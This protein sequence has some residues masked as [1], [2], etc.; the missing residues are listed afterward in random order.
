MHSSTNTR[1]VPLAIGLLLFA[2]LAGCAGGDDAGGAQP[3]GADGTRRAEARSPGK[4]GV[5]SMVTA[6]SAT[7]KPGAPVDLKF[8][9]ASKPELGKPLQVTVAVVPRSA[10]ISQL[11]LLFQSN[12]A[13]DVQSGSETVADAPADGVAVTHVVTVVPKRE[14][15]YYL[16]AV[17]LVE[18][19]GGSVAR[20][21][22]IPIIV[23]DPVAAERALADKPAQGTLA[24]GEAGEPIVSLPA[25]ESP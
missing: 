16:G 12:E 8:D 4:D 18:G 14:G 10:E 3:Q 20:S 25:S 19:A 11:R 17:A 5:A 9:I 21:F 2:A 7:G 6:V 1:T 23:G 15:V 13:F 22:A 24:K